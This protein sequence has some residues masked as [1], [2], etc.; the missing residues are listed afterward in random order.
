MAETLLA[1]KIAP[2]RAA[3]YM[4]LAERLARPELLLS[5]LGAQVREVAP[6]LLAGH[7]YLRVAV[8]GTV[9]PL[10]AFAMLSEWFELF[11]SLGGEPGPFLRPLAPSETLRFPPELVEAR[12]YRGKTNELFTHFLINVARWSHG[13]QPL[14]LFDP[15]AGGGTTLLTA[16]RLGMSVMGVERDKES[17]TGT[18][19]FLKLFL[20]GERHKYQR[21]QHKRKVGM[22]VHYAL[23]TGQQFVLAQGDTRQSETLLEALPGNPRPD[24]IVADL[25]YSI[26]HNA[27]LPL[28][29]LLKEALPAW[30][31]LAAPDAILTLAWN[32]TQLERATLSEWVAAGGWQP[33]EG[34]PYEEMDHQVDRVIKARD[35]LVA[36]RVG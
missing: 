14:W 5:P 6:L 30:Q 18:D 9:G 20:Q 16:W 34:G 31:R 8:E 7:P 11:D 23:P 10:P 25:P 1:A 13:G 28:S 3:Q 35:V 4:D 24:L 21:E 15:M 32:A 26:Q 33:L 36:R 22:R 29:A 19:T 2:Q 12:R 17:V 27:R